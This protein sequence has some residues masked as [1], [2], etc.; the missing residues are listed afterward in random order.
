MLFIITK[1]QRVISHKMNIIQNSFAKVY[2]DRNRKKVEINWLS[3]PAK[4]D[5]SF[6]MNMVERL[7][8]KHQIQQLIQNNLHS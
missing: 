8:N 3:E 1:F 7:M 4:E 2:L 6:L 5:Y